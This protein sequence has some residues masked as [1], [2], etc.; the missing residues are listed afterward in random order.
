MN[1]STSLEASDRPGGS[2]PILDYMKAHQL[3]HTRETYLSL[4]DLKEP[5]DP[6]LE[7]QLPRDFQLDPP[8]QSA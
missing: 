6:E 5:L 7:Q 8:E 4:A 3:P 2:D 1:T